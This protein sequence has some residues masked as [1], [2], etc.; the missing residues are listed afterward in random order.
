M[1]LLYDI[2]VIIVLGFIC[3]ANSLVMVETWAKE[4]ED[5]LRTFLRL[6]HGIPSH[7]TMSRLL[8]RLDT[9]QLKQCLIR[10]SDA[11]RTSASDGVIAIDGKTLRKTFDE[12]AKR[13][14]I[15][16]VSAFC[17]TEH[18]VLGQIRTLA[19]KNEV[20]AI[21]ALLPLLDIK[22]SIVTIDAMGRQKSI[23]KLILKQGGDFVL[24]LKANHKRLH[25]KVIQQFERLNTG[26]K[27]PSRASLFACHQAYDKAHGRIEHRKV[28]AMDVQDWLTEKT[29][30]AWASVVCSV[31]RVES[32]RTLKGKTTTELRY[33]L[34][35]LTYDHVIR[36][37]QA[38]RSH[39]SIENQLHWVLDV[40]FDQDRARL[41]KD[42]AP[43]NP[44]MMQSMSL[45]MLRQHIDPK[46]PRASLPQ[47]Q[48][49]AMCNDRYLLEISQC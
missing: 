16:M 27:P 24:A 39:W 15:H 19:K 47:K 41:R 23:A 26:F 44:A 14:A 22:G 37:A 4:K 17:S 28:T 10:W 40:T 18:L 11:L 36:I 25:R 48:L 6:P 33:Y 38:I 7:D 49:K 21:Q 31:V 35:S 42:H 2:L 5:F 1:H 13:V 46:S 20:A 3:V 29:Y 43:E 8:A 12:A 9:E 45:N 34:S 32:T 30:G